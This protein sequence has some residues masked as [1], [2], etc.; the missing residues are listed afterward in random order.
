MRLH[1]I[2][3]GIL[4]LLVLVVLGKT[5]WSWRA[6]IAPISAS[7]RVN[8]DRQAVA[9]G[10]ALAA[11]GNCSNC[12]DVPADPYAGGRPIPTPFGTIF[13]SNI[14]PDA[15]TGIGTWS[16]AAFRRAMQGGVDREGRQVC[17]RR[18]PSIILRTQRMTTFMHFTD[19]IVRFPIA[20]GFRRKRCPFPS[21]SARWS[22]AG[23]CYFSVTLNLRRAT[24]VRVTTGTEGDI[25]SKA[26]AI[27]G[28]ATPHAMRLEP[29]SATEPMP[30]ELR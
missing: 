4:G 13:A 6:A 18:F 30:A 1:E 3:L 16:E 17:P 14:T 20:I 7:E 22:L 11:I 12:T 2:V 29:R 24:R 19:L 9:R 15:E 23:N 8:I 21:I 26:W 28:P 10:A 27:A 25:S 5:S